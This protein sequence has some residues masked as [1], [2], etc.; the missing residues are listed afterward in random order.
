MRISAALLL[1]AIVILLLANLIV[2]PIIGMNIVT[3]FYFET[4]GVYSQYNYKDHLLLVNNKGMMEVDEKGKEKWNVEKQLTNFLVDIAG[5]YIMFADLEGTPYAGVYKDGKVQQEIKPS[6]GI[7]TAKVNKNGYAAVAVKEDGYK[8]MVSVYTNRQKNLYTWHSGEGYITD[9]EL[10]EN[11]RYLAVAQMMTDGETAYTRINFI[12]IRKGETI[13]TANRENVI[14][15]NL[16]YEKDGSLITVSD[17]D[18]AGYAADGKLLFEINLEGKKPTL[19]QTEEDNLLFLSADGRGNSILDIYTKRGKLKGTYTANGEIKNIA[20]CGSVIV[21]NQM[22]DVLY[23]G[24]N[25]KLRRTVPIDHD[26]KSI[27]IFGNR[28]NVLV[29]GGNKADIIRIR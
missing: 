15:S 13:A 21:A 4:G 28:R 5:E 8:G 7:I 16:N 1:L 25:G 19:F 20:V 18:A 6:S 22:R 24:T 10:S 3:D 23:I 11:N 12:D 14:V 17:Q 27:G 29:M 26:I 2:I 9:V